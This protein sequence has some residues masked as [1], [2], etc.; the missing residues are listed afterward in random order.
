MNNPE[1]STDAVADKSASP[2]AKGSESTT[3]ETEKKARELTNLYH[4]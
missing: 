2:N 4:L 1:K 3:S